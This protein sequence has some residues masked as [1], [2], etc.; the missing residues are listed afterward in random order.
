MALEAN[1]TPHSS[2][3]NII[4]QSMGWIAQ[5]VECGA[6][7]PGAVLT[8][9][10]EFF[11]GVHFQCSL[12]FGVCTALFVIPCSNVCAHIRNPEHLQPY[13]WA[14]ETPH[15]LGRLGSAA[16]VAFVALPGWGT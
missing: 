14:Q 7:K 12:S 1:I 10:R 8:C 3:L 11:P 5:W 9:T 15:T 16:F 4:N 13:Q 6:K 2:T